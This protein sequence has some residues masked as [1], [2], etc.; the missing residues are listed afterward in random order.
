MSR[1]PPQTLHGLSRALEA[2]AGWGED[3]EEIVR[4]G[5]GGRTTVQGR[6]AP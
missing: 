1:C 4:S 2:L 5:M 3:S 6:Y